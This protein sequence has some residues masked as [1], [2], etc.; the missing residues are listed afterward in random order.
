MGCVGCGFVARNYVLWGS[1]VLPFPVENRGGS[2]TGLC[3]GID[4]ILPRLHLEA[5]DVITSKLLDKKLWLQR[6]SKET[7]DCNSEDCRLSNYQK[8]LRSL[9]QKGIGRGFRVGNKGNKPRFVGGK[10]EEENW[11]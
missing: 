2:G 1:S 6:F 11:D 4:A 3:Y 10:T 5:T 7:I 9:R 8:V